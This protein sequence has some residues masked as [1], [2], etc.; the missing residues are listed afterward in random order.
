VT[1][2]LLKEDNKMKRGFSF[3]SSV[4][5]GS[6]VVAISLGLVAAQNATAFCSRSHNWGH[7]ET[8]GTSPLD[9]SSVKSKQIPTELKALDSFDKAFTNFRDQCDK[10][11]QSAK[12]TSI[13]WARLRSS[14]V[15]LKATIPAE[16]NAVRSIIN[17]AKAKG[18]W[19]SEM[20]AIVVEQL[21][22]SSLDSRAKRE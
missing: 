19:N 17:K 7:S 8:A 22:Q 10:L 9:S 5:R 3:Q 12:V 2:K 11:D 6:I 14:A 13:E 4:I 15:R 1:L 20:D 16:E 18:K 21:R